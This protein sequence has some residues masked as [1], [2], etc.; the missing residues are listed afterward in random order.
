MAPYTNSAISI[1]KCAATNGHRVGVLTKIG[2]ARTPIERVA[3][4]SFSSF[5]AHRTAMEFHYFLASSFQIGSF[6][7]GIKVKAEQCA[8][9]VLDFARRGGDDYFCMY[10]PHVLEQIP[11]S[12]LV[13]RSKYGQ[14]FDM[15]HEN[16][17]EFIE[18]YLQFNHGRGE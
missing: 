10:T 6:V 18:R 17:A 9:R 8:D 12:C 13:I 15:A 2:Q 3:M 16:D 11:C 7:N 14:L 5:Q 1:R 4:T